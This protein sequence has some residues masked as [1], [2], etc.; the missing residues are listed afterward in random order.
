MSCFE[1][2]S[3]LLMEP[4]LRIV[5]PF[6]SSASLT[7]SFVGSVTACG[8]M[9]TNAEF[10][11]P[12][13]LMVGAAPP[14][15]INGRGTGR[16][17][18]P[19]AGTSASTSRFLVILC[20]TWGNEA[21]PRGPL[22]AA[23]MLRRAFSLVLWAT[24]HADDTNPAEARRARIAEQL[25][26]L[27]ARGDELTA[28]NAQAMAEH[29]CDGETS[30]S[31]RAA[32]AIAALKARGRE[33]DAKYELGGQTLLAEQPASV[34]P[35]P[36]ANLEVSSQQNEDTALDKLRARVAADRARRAHNREAR[37]ASADRTLDSAAARR[38]RARRR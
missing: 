16:G 12:S 24:A 34:E 33:L 25:S 3:S 10:F 32:A 13:A 11:G 38:A 8:L 20:S 22:A 9:K 23:E 2:I 15:R 4:S 30:T 5:R 31:S 19:M 18:K 6:A 36:A 17:T 37:D 7:S 21:W 35:A 27:R 28:W 26:R 1:S 29:T 14:R